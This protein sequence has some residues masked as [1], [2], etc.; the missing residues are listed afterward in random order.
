MPFARSRGGN[1]G[2]RR[3]TIS[4][5]AFAIGDLA[6]YDRSN[7]VVVKATSSTSVEDIIGVCVEATTTADTSV[8]VQ[9]L[10]E[11]DEFVANTTNN[12]S[13][14]HNYQRMILTDAATVNN[15]GTDST[16]DAAVVVQMA[17]VGAASAKK[18]ACRFV[19]I[20]DRA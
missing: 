10:E 5:V 1:R 15:T 7:A 6:A 14:T 11:G 13:A 19:R 12:S 3:Y 16:N 20:Q 2:F 17:P 18:I 8:L 9:E 4:S